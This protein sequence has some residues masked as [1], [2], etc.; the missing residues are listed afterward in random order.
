MKKNSYKR[1]HHQTNLS[2]FSFW[3]F[4]FVPQSI[5]I[6]SRFNRHNNFELHNYLIWLRM[7]DFIRVYFYYKSVFDWANSITNTGYY[8]DGVIFVLIK[9]KVSLIYKSYSF[10]INHF[11][12]LTFLAIWKQI[13]WIISECLSIIAHHIDASSFYLKHFF[14]KNSF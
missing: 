11:I 14:M 7:T 6:E 5:F 1:P 2:G 10:Q 3:T 4:F 9:S 8:I 12:F 13:S